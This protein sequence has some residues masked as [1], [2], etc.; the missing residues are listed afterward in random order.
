MKIF[1]R[2]GGLEI[3]SPAKLN[4]YLDIVGKRVDGYHQVLTLMQEITL[5]DSLE[6]FPQGREGIQLTSTDPTIPLGGDN[7]IVRAARRFLDRYP[8]SSG[9]RI[10]L[11]KKIPA[12]AGLG[13]GSGNASAT[14]IGLNHLFQ[15]KLTPE[16]LA[17]EASGI[18]SD[19]P[20]FIY[21]GSALCESRGEQVKVWPALRPFSVLIV[22]PTQTCSTAQ[23]YRALTLP[24]S[25]EPQ[26]PVDL[27]FEEL[28]SGEINRVRAALYNR[29]EDV[30]IKIYPELGIF[31]ERLA[32]WGL[33]SP[34]LTGS[35][36]AFFGIFES[37]EA[38]KAVQIEI[39]KQL[40]GA[41]RGVFIAEFCSS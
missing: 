32:A 20:F 2:D 41:H 34:R 29:L 31:R 37:V 28:R 8:V 13:G 26:R 35:G 10:H 36:S 6:I 33:P 14:L 16:V 7:L 11:R 38:A 5:A 22:C 25:P 30:V 12:A 3:I 27:V 1:E 4:L 18:G 39:E 40:S 15:K 24:S 23:V 21:G 9:V 19:C 17:N